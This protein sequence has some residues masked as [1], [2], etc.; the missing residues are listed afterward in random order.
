MLRCTALALAIGIA[1]LFPTRGQAQV[2]PSDLDALG[3]QAIA[4]FSGV[5]D[6]P[7]SDRLSDLVTDNEG[8]VYVTGVFTGSGF[9]VKGYLDDE[10][11]N[12]GA[13]VPT[14]SMP[15]LNSLGAEDIFVAKYDRFGKLLWARSAGGAGADYVSGIAVD[16]NGR[17]VVTVSSNAPANFGGVIFTPAPSFV[18]DQDGSEVGQTLSAIAVATI[19]KNGD[20]L[21][22]EPLEFG[23]EVEVYE[24]AGGPQ[25]SATPIYVSN[26]TGFG[27]G[28]ARGMVSDGSGNL[29]LK[30]LCNFTGFYVP[31]QERTT[32][33]VWF[34]Y[35]RIGDARFHL[36]RSQ[37]VGG[38]DD[39]NFQTTVFQLGN[40]FVA[41]LLP[42]A[43]DS[44]GAGYT[45]SWATAVNPVSPDRFASFPLGSSVIFDVAVSPTGKVAMAGQASGSISNGPGVTNIGTRLDGFIA[46]LNGQTGGIS[47]L[48]LTRGS[49]I[50]QAPVKSIDFDSGGNLFA[51]VN[52]LGSG[53]FTFTRVNSSQVQQ[54][55]L[56]GFSVKALI[57]KL[58]TA[59]DWNWLETV[60]SA[61]ATLAE[62][63]DV[64][65][66][67]AAYLTGLASRNAAGT[68]DS[69]AYLSKLT[70]SGGV[71]SFAWTRAIVPNALAAHGQ[72]LRLTSS[73]SLLWVVG[74]GLSYGAA[75]PVDGSLS[76]RQGG[77]TDF[78]RQGGSVFYALDTDGIFLPEPSDTLVVLAGA[79]VTPP[80]GVGLDGD[81]KVLQP[82]LA[83]NGTVRALEPFFYWSVPEGK[84]YATAAVTAEV[85]WRTTSDL[86]VT[87]RITRPV[88]VEWPVSVQRYVVAPEQAPVELEPVGVTATFQRIIFSLPATGASILGNKTLTASGAGYVTLLF[89]EG[90]GTAEGS[91]ALPR[92][93]IVQVFRVGD[94]GVIGAG[95]N[96][97]IGLAL[98]G[99]AAGHNDPTGK[100]GFVV[101]RKARVD[102][103]GDARSYDRATR[104]GSI[105]PVN[106]DDSSSTDD[107]LVVIWY[108]VSTDGIVWPASAVQY[109]AVWPAATERIVVASQLGNDLPGQEALDPARFSAMS[110]Y[111]QP[112]RNLAGYNP[113]EEH[114]L[115]VPSRKFGHSAVYALRNDLNNYPPGVATSAPYVLLRYRDATRNHAP[116]FK[117][118]KVEITDP[119]YQGFDNFFVSNTDG[120]LLPAV[121]G[122]KVP[123]PYPL[124]LLVADVR[125][126]GDGL[127][128]FEDYKGD[129]WAR[130]AGD[131][132]V[133]YW[134][135]L[136][137]DFWVDRNGDGVAD[138]ETAQPWL[139][140]YNRS[141]NS[142]APAFTPVTVRYRAGWPAA[143]PEL[144]V[145][146]TLQTAMRGLPAVQNWAAGRIIFDE[147]EPRLGHIDGNLAAQADSAATMVRF[148]DPISLR[149][150]WVPAS[151]N[152][153]RV[154]IGQSTFPVEL[155]DDG[156]YRFSQLPPHLAERLRFNNAGNTPT[157]A[158]EFSGFQGIYN[159]EELFLINVLSTAERDELLA[160][161]GTAGDTGT[162]WDA[163]IVELHTLTRDPNGVG[164][165]AINI[166]LTRDAAGRIVQDNIRG[167]KA[168]TAGLGTGVGY[169]TLVE[170]DDA[171]LDGLPV[172]LHVIKVGAPQVTGSLKLIKPADA[173]KER[174]DLRHSG[175][176]SGDPDRLNF[177]WFIAPDPLPPDF[178]ANQG[179]YPPSAPWVKVAEGLGINQI[180]IEG[181]GLRTL[182]DQWAFVRYAGYDIRSR[183]GREKS[184]VLIERQ[185]ELIGRSFDLYDAGGKPVRVYFDF[186]VLPP[187]PVPPQGRLLR[188][189]L[190]GAT[191]AA[192]A[193]DLTRQILN[194]DPSF[195]SFAVGNQVTVFSEIPGVRPDV[196]DVDAVAAGVV[197]SVVQ[198]GSLATQ[199]RTVITMPGLGGVAGKYFD[200]AD[201]AGP[202]RVW[203][204]RGILSGPTPLGGR[205]VPIVYSPSDSSAV[206][207]GRVR[208]ELNAQ[209]GGQTRFNVAAFSNLLEIEDAAMGTR[210]DIVDGAVPTGFNLGVLHQGGDGSPL[211]AP[212][213]FSGFAGDPASLSEA[214]PKFIPGW[215]KRVLEGVNLFAARVRDASAET[216]TYSS[217]V[218]QAGPRFEGP[219]A[220]NGSAANLNSVGLIQLYQTVLQR[221]LDLSVNVS[222]D[223]TSP[224]VDN[225]LLLAASRI[226]D[227]YMLLGNEAFADA[228]D[229]T[230]GFTTSDG[231]EQIA[232]PPDA[233]AFKNQLPSLMSE[234]LCLLRGRDRTGA[235][236]EGAP[237]Y[238]RLFWN[239]SRGLEGEPLYVQTYAIGDQ[240]TD[241]LL[242]PEDARVQFPQGH[243]DA[244]GHYLTS[245][246][247]YYRLL[248][249]PNFTW[250]PRA[251][252]TNVLGTA[253]LVDY[254]DEQKFAQNAAA[255]ARTGRNIV[256]LTYRNAYVA[257]PAGQ[258]QGYK[259][260]D[261]T[262]GWGVDEWSRRAG[263]GAYFDWV[264]GNAILPDVYD[265]NGVARPTELYPQGFAY[266]EPT[267]QKID[268]STVP[269]L[270]EVPAQFAAIEARVSAADRGLNP[271][272][273]D[274]DATPFDV[275]PNFNEVG[276][277]N[278]GET[279]FVQIYQRAITALNSAQKVWSYA[280]G[281]T[282]RLRNLQTSADEFTQQ[283]KEE[284]FNYRNR[285]IEIFGY[286]YQGDIGANGIYPS[287]YNGPDLIKYNYVN[288][289][290]SSGERVGPDTVISTQFR[291]LSLEVVRNAGGV[292]ETV[293]GYV[294]PDG[295]TAEAVNR[296][297]QVDFAV[298]TSSLT[299]WPFAATAP[300]GSRRA[301]GQL[302]AAIRELIQ[303][304][305][306]LQAT[307]TEYDNHLQ[308]ITRQT[309]FLAARYAVTTD[310]LAIRIKS[311]DQLIAFNSTIGILT[312]LS[313]SIQAAV[314]GTGEFLEATAATLPTELTDFFAPIRGTAKVSK[315]AAIQALNTVKT[316]ADVSANSLE[317]AK[318]GVQ[319]TNDLEIEKRD[320]SLEVQEALQELEQT[321]RAEIPLRIA[322]FKAQQQVQS[323]M[324]AYNT[325]LATGQQV[326]EERKIF[327]QKVAGA[328]QNNRYQDIA[329]RSFRNSALAKYRA[330]F[331]LAAQYTYFTA[332]AYDY[333]TNL[334]GSNA[335]A[336]REF[337]TDIVKHR[338]LG[339]FDEDGPLNGVAGLSD[340]MAR[341]AQNFDVLKGQLGIT[342]PSFEADRI[343][344]REALFR[345]PLPEEAPEEGET[346]REKAERLERNAEA[347]QNWRDAL[348]T[349][350]PGGIAKARV[351][352]NLFDLPEF[353]RY[354]RPFAVDNGV[355]QPGLVIE[356]PTAIQQ[357]ANLFNRELAGGDFAYDPTQFTTKIR[358]ASIFLKGYTDLGLAAAPRVYLVPVGTDIMLSP[359]GNTLQTREFRVVDQ[360]IPEPFPIGT[361]NLIDPSYIPQNDGLNGAFAQ[362]RRYSTLR[363]YDS[364]VSE[365]DIFL[366]SRLI[367]RSVWNTRWVLIIPGATFA[368]DPQA[369]LDAFLA[370]V[371]DIELSLNTYSYSGN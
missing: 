182:S 70:E 20:W 335:G 66:T 56:P 370:G 102:A 82:E 359:G 18:A 41:K 72:R 10:N 209:A 241:G 205:L 192:S 260:S 329:F 108:Q 134:Y 237:V 113:N 272:G 281:L 210:T 230:V 135:G 75:Y 122:Q 137:P 89:T 65:S 160:F 326:M 211:I 371:E 109:T 131:V 83:V 199:E 221:G 40:A 198:Q 233:F 29:Y 276:S 321:I 59:G 352:G 54:T 104:E 8:N 138:P 299:G 315:A 309:D 369:G 168:L 337:L 24:G 308:S 32:S 161:D 14:V 355:P 80:V 278:Q 340:P 171:A 196:K 157:K 30:G 316:I 240:N 47:T 279:H 27:V 275:D 42:D 177:E 206:L 123:P 67:G 325:T 5:M 262:R 351:V 165:A 39:G 222:P 213:D 364:D 114:A 125:T 218:Q 49:G 95:P 105:I 362:I 69:Y 356:F 17:A 1:L 35:A 366:D 347:D 358:S 88:T 282:Q 286:P 195:H 107:D 112:D 79:E 156:R 365:G 328:V 154:T 48:S 153:L 247:L 307:K 361:S 98:N 12:G 21:G 313:T 173:L 301:E 37:Y 288:V 116:A 133:R 197:L 353:R 179:T 103:V 25:A 208:A 155:T 86:T 139:D 253:V 330:A 174:V 22:V 317:L 305:S 367:S 145:G 258:W 16:R 178:P 91:A 293:S 38:T 71:R 148:F 33:K 68:G 149:R 302:Q 144:R 87:T 319:L 150:V 300:M 191:D 350:H 252:N 243:G 338:S 310:K 339:Q 193:A 320:F 314:V 289:V 74:S 46:V 55:S 52:L 2:P 270:S 194:L 238:N 226:S 176:F 225:A 268:R 249:H 6:G 92:L 61:N 94:P 185:V 216:Q 348:R 322:L 292:F 166:G 60:P 285:L 250:R 184:R 274:N 169:V 93:R 323:A 43:S 201:Q 311:R 159:E 64:D 44:S 266:V 263:Q 3:S 341:M 368:A 77:A 188:V 190:A 172:A 312:A 11:D 295:T 4:P 224:G 50:S 51:G 332:R 164:G 187:P 110:I 344:L 146:E 58:D 120:T 85:R 100:S 245:S 294:F 158:L 181:S 261:A 318:E 239:F 57:A 170:N 228:E 265:P 227:L 147:N 128:Y 76:T 19:D 84:L 254:Q 132:Q 189:N 255:K 271:L 73:G 331:D 229:P 162:V 212:G 203:F 349:S 96:V 232:P 63:I 163:A 346:N 45:L 97:P 34:Y 296:I 142:G 111:H 287:G 304:Q 242:A 244:W 269:D 124:S 357:G 141:V 202:V 264:V 363:A 236:I 291:P 126:E 101:N 327:R 306:D 15:V 297:Q 259:D 207:A 167:P 115:I 183:P 78:L 219:V 136:R 151:F 13:V 345:V 257:D 106:L 267:L 246:K 175:D 334:L 118:Y 360:R 343:S 140:L 200:L 298:N 217:A 342:N 273:L 354:C 277:G 62:S 23:F 290:D 130:S 283:V 214:R 215:I 303:A 129:V 220:L 235:G 333:E 231:V 186:G 127:A 223:F 99:A 9:E 7:A 336:G 119:D 251:E 256:D 180:R 152:A 53:T 204:T 284:E 248:R 90:A 36:G 280:N 28:A 31:P 324:E 143:A 26:G 121:A 81:G 117:V 234:E